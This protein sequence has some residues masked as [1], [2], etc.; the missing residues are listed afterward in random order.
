MVRHLHTKQVENK[1]Q[2]YIMIVTEMKREKLK[3]NKYYKQLWLK[4]NDIYTV[5]IDLLI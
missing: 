3:V 4:L 1:E 5:K 2:I